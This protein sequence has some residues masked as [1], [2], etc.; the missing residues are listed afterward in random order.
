MR[1]YNLGAPIEKIECTKKEDNPLH[2]N[3]EMMNKGYFYSRSSNGGYGVFYKRPTAEQ[4]LGWLQDKRITIEI[5]TSINS[6]GEL[7]YFF[8]A[9]IPLIDIMSTSSSYSYKRGILDIINN[10]LDII[11]QQQQQKQQ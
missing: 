10:I 2:K 4:M 5:K 9:T 3:I 11:E 1:A 8:V 7:I 6:Y